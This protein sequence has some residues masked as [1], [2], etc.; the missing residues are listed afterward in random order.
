MYHRLRR[1]LFPNPLLLSRN[2]FRL[3]SFDTDF[4]DSTWYIIAQLSFRTYVGI[5]APISPNNR[6][7]TRPLSSPAISKPYTACIT[8]AS[9]DVVT[10]GLLLIT[11]E[12]STHWRNSPTF[13]FLKKN[14]N[15][16]ADSNLRSISGPRKN[17]PVSQC[18]P[19]EISFSPQLM[20]GNLIRYAHS[21]F[22]F[23]IAFSEKPRCAP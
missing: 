8:P 21:P 10:L 23:R 1:E 20:I 19:I 6:S 15:E 5:S 12:T 22:N 18:I 4:V 17:F 2:P 3:F 13:R 7:G 9:L 11:R 16:A 14:S